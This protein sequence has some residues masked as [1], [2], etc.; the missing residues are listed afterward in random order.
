MKLLSLKNVARVLV[1]L[2]LLAVVVPFSAA[3]QGRERGRGDGLGKKCEKF[4]NCHDARDGRWDGRGPDRSSH[5]SYRSY[6]SHRS[7]RSGRHHDN[8]WRR[9]GVTRHVRWN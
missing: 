4:V 7:Y 3:G 2:G 9:H 8:D 1:V 5:R 6:R